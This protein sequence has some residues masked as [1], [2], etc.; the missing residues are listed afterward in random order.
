MKSN[1]KTNNNGNES[2]YFYAGRIWGLYKKAAIE[3]GFYPE[4]TYELPF[5]RC[6][7]CI[8]DEL[9]K[10]FKEVINKHNDGKT[11]IEINSLKHQIK[12][13]EMF[14]IHDFMTARQ[15]YEFTKGVESVK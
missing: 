12:D 6:V 7:G 5:D 4:I 14:L 9:E 2:P 1:N 3:I 10:T 13:S 15:G 11:L 8:I